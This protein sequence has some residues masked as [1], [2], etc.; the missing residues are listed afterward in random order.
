MAIERIVTL[1]ELK[2]YLDN[3]LTL[4][5]VI[6]QA[7]FNHGV[8]K[9]FDHSPE[10]MKGQRFR[11]FVMPLDSKGKPLTKLAKGQNI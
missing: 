1:T 7:E 4:A 9:V 2:K 8:V 10:A 6:T 3:S 5:E 11:Y